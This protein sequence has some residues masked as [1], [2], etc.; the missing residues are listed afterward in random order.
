[1][2][3]LVYK[4]RHNQWPTREQV[5]PATRRHPRDAVEGEFPSLGEKAVLTRLN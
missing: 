5:E 4:L 3:R 1:M 2:R